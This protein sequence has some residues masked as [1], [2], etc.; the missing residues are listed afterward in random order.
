MGARWLGEGPDTTDRRGKSSPSS[1]RKAEES[2][3]SKRKG[4]I[5]KYKIRVR[6]VSGE[7]RVVKKCIDETMKECHANDKNLRQKREC[8]TKMLEISTSAGEQIGGKFWGY[9]FV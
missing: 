4:L 7:T 6:V 9:D 3:K 5:W 2:H 8:I 1:K